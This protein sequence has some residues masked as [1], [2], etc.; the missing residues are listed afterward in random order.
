MTPDEILR[1]FSQPLQTEEPKEWLLKH[2]GH[3]KRQGF[4][5]D[6]KTGNEYVLWYCLKCRIFYI[7]DKIVLC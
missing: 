3:A 5:F 2:R 4:A 1:L 7:G 6:E